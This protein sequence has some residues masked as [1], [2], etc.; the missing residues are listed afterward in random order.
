MLNLG[1]LK[2][3][4]NVWSIFTFSVVPKNGW[5]GAQGIVPKRETFVIVK[6]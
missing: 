1:S 4:D 2:R 6:I 3:P 5:L